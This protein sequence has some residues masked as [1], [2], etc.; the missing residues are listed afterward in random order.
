M[1]FGLGLELTGD[2]RELQE[3]IFVFEITVVRVLVI[4]LAVPE[5]GGGWSN[6]LS[7]SMER[8][9]VLNSRETAQYTR[10]L[11]ETLTMTSRWATDSRTMI[12]RGGM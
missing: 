8:R 10:K 9:V 2:S 4:L 1:I 11:E 7:L 6:F 3:G 12:S 5:E